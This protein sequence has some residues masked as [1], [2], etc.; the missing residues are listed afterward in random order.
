[1][2]QDGDSEDST[3]SLRRGSGHQAQADL[4]SL[5]DAADKAA[6]LAGTTE[7]CG[8]LP[9][10]IGCRY[11]VVPEDDEFGPPKDPAAASGRQIFAPAQ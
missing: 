9:Q 1:V 10:R 2:Q 6:R 5:V 4:Q 8:G 7:G 11:I 3:W